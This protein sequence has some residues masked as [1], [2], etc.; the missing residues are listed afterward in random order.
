MPAIRTT[1]SRQAPPTDGRSVARSRRAPS[2]TLELKSSGASTASAVSATP[3]CRA[4]GKL[5]VS[6][7]PD[8]VP[9]AVG[10]GH[11]FRVAKTGSP[12]TTAWSAESRMRDA[13]LRVS[14]HVYACLRHG[15]I[16]EARFATR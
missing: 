15:A 10:G 1:T 16:A 13:T 5:R 6:H 9:I 2:G 4:I 3:T 12:N 14:D 7:S 8:T 11:R